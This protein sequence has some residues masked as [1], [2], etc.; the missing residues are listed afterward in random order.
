[1]T[2]RLEEQPTG[3][4]RIATMDLPATPKNGLMAAEN[5][6]AFR[7]RWVSI[8]TGFVDEPSRAVKEAD[9]LVAEVMKRLAEVFAH[10]RSKLEEQW[11]RQKEVSTEDLRVVLQRYRSF[12]DRLLGVR[13]P[14]GA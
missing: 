3:T 1:M 7:S 4:A 12:F 11:A 10:E 2:E 8:Q 5:E 13:A 6:E 9:E 14:G